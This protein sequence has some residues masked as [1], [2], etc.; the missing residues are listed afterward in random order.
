VVKYHDT[1]GMECVYICE[2][3]QNYLQAQVNLVIGDQLDIYIKPQSNMTC[4]EL[5]SILEYLASDILKRLKIKIS[6]NCH[7]YIKY[8]E[9][10]FTVELTDSVATGITEQPA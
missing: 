10:T 2:K 4:G 8:D 6:E 1:I 5:N 9:K 7:V 3:T